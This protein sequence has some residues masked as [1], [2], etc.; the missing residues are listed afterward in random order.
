MD[1]KPNITK[2]GKYFI[3]MD[4]GTE[5]TDIRRKL[6]LDRYALKNDEGDAIEKYPEQSWRRMSWALAQT[7][8]T[9]KDRVH[10][11]KKFYEAMDGFKFVPAGRVWCSAGTGTKA[12]M[13]N[14]FVLPNPEDTRQ[15]IIKTL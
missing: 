15:G 11:E 10:W 12:T 8:K 2:L 4:S 1:T 13:I 3:D 6:F 5:L 7:E 9:K 14:C